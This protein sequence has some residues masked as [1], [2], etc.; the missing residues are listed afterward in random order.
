MKTMTLNEFKAF[1]DRDDWVRKT[2]IGIIDTEEKNV[3]RKEGEIT[4][5]HTCGMGMFE[6]ALDGVSIFYKEVFDYDDYDIQSFRKTVEGIEEVLS[7]SGLK[8]V[9]DNGDDFIDWRDLVPADFKNIDYDEIY[10]A[11]DACVDV[12]VDEDSGKGLIKIKVDNAPDIRFSGDE[13]AQFS[14]SWDS[15]Q[16]HFSGEE[17]WRTEL[18][19]YKTIYGKWICQKVHETKWL[20][21]KDELSA[22]VCTSLDEVKQ[23]FGD[24]W[25]AKKL[26][27]KLPSE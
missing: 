20:D 13:I 6:S 16:L 10:K 23:F 8:I 21:Q 26:Y 17:G 22:K 19:L 24:D 9:D 3:K 15:T 5:F 27:E 2:R 12:D 1:L 4:V 11:L 18:I 14:S 25:V 7:I